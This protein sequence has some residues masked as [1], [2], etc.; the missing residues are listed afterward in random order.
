MRRGTVEAQPCQPPGVLGPRSSCGPKEP[1]VTGMEYLIC[2]REER[3]MFGLL[4]SPSRNE[5]SEKETPGA[6]GQVWANPST[7]GHPGHSLEML[8]KLPVCMFSVKGSGGPPCCREVAGQVSLLLSSYCAMLL[9]EIR[10][11]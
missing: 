9:G 4:F 10:R 11:F 5:I 6:P 1:Q 3:R 7:S 2:K 8:Q